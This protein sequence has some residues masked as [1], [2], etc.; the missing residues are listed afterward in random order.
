DF[1]DRL[2]A[3]IEKSKLLAILLLRGGSQV[4]GVKELGRRQ[5]EPCFGQRQSGLA[6]V[7]LVRQFFDFSLGAVGAR[8]GCP[9]DALRVKRHGPGSAGETEN[10]VQENQNLA[11]G[12]HEQV[13]LVGYDS[14]VIA[15]WV[16]IPIVTKR[17]RHD[18][19]RSPHQGSICSS[20]L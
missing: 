17:R 18:R 5:V 3:G 13:S 20:S 16:T 15:L 12:G 6:L 14:I 7:D 2:I 10:Q 1:L 11:K 8:F 9:V 4:F 19:N